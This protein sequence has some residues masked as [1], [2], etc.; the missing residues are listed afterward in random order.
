LPRTLDIEQVLAI[1]QDTLNRRYL[2]TVHLLAVD[3]DP[4][5]L[6]RLE[7]QLPR[8]GIHVTTLD[9]P[10]RL[11]ETL[12]DLSPDLLL[13]D[14]DMPHLDG[15]QLCHIIR[16][17]SRWIGLPIL[18]LT[19]CQDTNTIQ[20]IFTVGGD[21]YIPKPFTEPELVTRVF[22]RLERSQK[23]HLAS[24]LGDIPSGLLAEQAALAAL[25]RDLMLA[26]QYQQSYCLGMITW[27][28][29]ALADGAEPPAQIHP[30]LQDVVRALKADLRRADII[31]QFHPGTIT[32]GLYGVGEQAAHRRFQHLLKP[33]NQNRWGHSGTAIEFRYRIVTAPEDGITVFTLRQTLIERLPVGFKE[34][35]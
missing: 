5:I 6:Q 22:K 28:S 32:V 29:A 9:D 4:I 34:P 24:A 8:W 20:R 14:V 31:T 2:S 3:D 7:Q 19:A 17:D 12:L 21:D 27:G 15:T 13:L 35:W 18:F 10:R 1:V 33:L 30:V 11:W 23:P 25:E 26:Q 16:S